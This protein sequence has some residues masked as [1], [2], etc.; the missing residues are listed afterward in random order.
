[1]T[2]DAA[3]TPRWSAVDLAT[4]L[5]QPDAPTPEQAAVIEAPLRPLLVVAGAGS[6]KTETM[7]ARVV[8]LVANGLVEPDQV[9]GLTFTRKAAAELSER[10]ASGCAT[11]RAGRALDAAGDEARRRGARRRPD[12]LDLPRVCRPAR[13]RARRC[14]SGSSR[15]AGCSPRPRPGSSPHEVVARWDGPMDGVEQGRVHRHRRPSSTSPARWPST[16]STPATSARHLDARRRP[17][18]SALPKGAEQARGPAR[19]RS[20]DARRRLRERARGAADRR[21]LPRAQARARRPG[22]RRPD[23]PGRPPRPPFREVGAAERPRFRAVLLDEFQDT[24]EA[25]LVLL[26]SLFVAPGQPVPVTA[27][28]DPHQSI[29]GWRGASADHA[30]RL[31]RRVR[32]RPGPR[33][34]AAA[35][36]ELAQRRRRSSTPPTPC[37]AAARDVAGSPSQ[38]LRPAPGGRARA[39]RRRPG[40]ATTE[41]EAGHVADVD[42]PRWLAP[43]RRTGARAAVLCRKRSQ[44]APVVEALRGAGLP[45][46]VVGLGGLLTTPEVA[47]IVALLLG[48]AGPHPRRPADAA[49]HRAR[50]AGSGAADLDGLGAWARAAA[51]AAPARRGRTAAPSLLRPDDAAEPAPSIVEARRRPAAA[52]DARVGRRTG[53]PARRRRPAPARGVARRRL[54]L[55]EAVRRAARRLTGLALADL[56][57]RGRASPSASTSRCSPRPELHA[58]RRP[59]APRRVRRRRGHLRRAAPTGPPW[60]FLAWLDAAVDEERGLDMGWIEARHRRRAG[61]HRARRQGPG[62]GRRRRPRAWSRASFPAHSAD[63]GTLVE[64]RLGRTPTPSDKGWLVGLSALPYDLRGDRDGLPRFGWRRRPRLGRRAARHSSASSRAVADHGIAEERRLAYVALTRARSDLLLTAHVWGRRVDP[65]GHLA[66]PRRG[67]GTPA[68]LGRG[69]RA[70]GRPAAE[71]DDGGKPQ[72]P[73][74][75]EAGQ[76]RPGRPLDHA[77]PR[78]EA[79]ARAGRGAVAV[80]LADAAAAG[81]GPPPASRPRAGWD[82]EIALLL[83]ERARRRSGAPV[84]VALPRHL[85]ASAVVALARGRR[86]RSPSTC[87]ARCRPRPPLAARRGTAFH[88]WVEQHYARAA[89]VDL[90]DLPGSADEDAGRR[91][92]LPR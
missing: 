14:G 9:L 76:R 16:S 22:L 39:R 12:R 42:R 37:R 70:V 13:A 40:C 74:T 51:S 62:V 55:R 91:R 59:G 11:L 41:D 90:L 15:S 27:V 84:D 8:W 29:Y 32:R 80:D 47:D 53:Q 81:R 82:G 46:E 54:R 36:D 21:A 72:N 48:G 69:R 19:P 52:A 56:V 10:I 66:L 34:R 23:G 77:A 78:R 2:A 38:P 50:R 65:A 79:A 5:G 25:Q 73:R 45:V 88:A 86:A 87:A 20:R 4:A 57:A 24:S 71:P 18:S 61:A 26:R 7:A 28:G 60:G 83:A 3:P 67:R 33:R 31:P 49:A 75:A 44:F 89:L 6:G 30:D 63:Q 17:R 64:R 58:R 92:D 85:S 68:E 1:M 43:R 35:V